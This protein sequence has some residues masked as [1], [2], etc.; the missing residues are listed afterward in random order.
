MFEDLDR[1]HQI[2]GV[3]GK[4]QMRGVT[5]RTREIA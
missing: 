1:H 3:V 2:E 5:E 4:R